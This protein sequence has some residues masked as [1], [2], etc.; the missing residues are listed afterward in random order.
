[1]TAWH[2]T[3]NASETGSWL[4]WG[5][6]GDSIW[7]GFLICKARRGKQNH[8]DFLIHLRLRKQWINRAVTWFCFTQIIVDMINPHSR[9]CILTF[10][11]WYAGRATRLCS[12]SYDGTAFLRA[13]SFQFLTASKIKLTLLPNQRQINN[14]AITNPG[15]NCGTAC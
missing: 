6:F 3:G 8:C 4:L 1:M 13:W 14:I 7:E 2:N 12:I 15:I 11:S 10:I 5:L 9:G